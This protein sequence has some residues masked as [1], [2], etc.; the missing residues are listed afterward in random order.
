MIKSRVIKHSQF[1]LVGKNISAQKYFHQSQRRFCPVTIY[2]ENKAAN[3]Y[4][5]S[6]LYEI[7]VGNSL[8][9]KGCIKYALL[10]IQIRGENP[11][12]QIAE[13]VSPAL[14]SPPRCSLETLFCISIHY[15][16]L[17]FIAFTKRIAIQ[18]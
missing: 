16:V 13:S 17:H 10:Q 9:F 18:L 8:C 7:S 3:I 15:I 1:V 14:F 11:N 4:L 12:T 2:K 5:F 6:G